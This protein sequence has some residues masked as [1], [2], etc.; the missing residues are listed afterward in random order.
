M[1][2]KDVELLTIPGRSGEMIIEPGR[3]FVG[4]LLCVLAAVYALYLI[5]VA[6]RRVRLTV[7]RGVNLRIL[8]YELVICAAFMIL[9]L[10]VRFGLGT[11]LRFEPLAW[12]ARTGAL[13]LAIP[14]AL[15]AGRI[16][17]HLRDRPAADA[18]CA[19]VLGMA[20][21]GGAPN[22]DLIYRVEAAREWALAH[23]AA[24][25]IVAG[26]NGAGNG[27]SEAAVM[28][29]LLVERGVSGDSV[30]LEDRSTDT[31]ENFANAVRML[32]PGEPVVIVTSG[33]HMPRA[34]SIAK[35]AGFAAPAGLSA[36]CDPWLFPANASWE[37]VCEFDRLA[38]RAR[39]RADRHA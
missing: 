25:L 21:E 34:L 31:G 17:G 33:Y 29:A 37:I 18:D 38:K 3:L 16:A 6:L 7:D 10:D 28:K 4:R 26:G 1:P 30:A 24:R 23:P 35:A 8:G 36:P 27:P 13:A 2:E 39:S 11:L 22:R 32:D 15:L 20:L 12:L 19:L 14:T 5:V 9:A